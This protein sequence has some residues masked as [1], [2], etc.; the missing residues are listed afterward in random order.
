M[1]SNRSA[2]DINRDFFIFWAHLEVQLDSNTQRLLGAVDS[3]QADV[4]QESL[5][6]VLLPQVLPGVGDGGPEV[7]VDIL[8][9]DGGDVGVDERLGGNSIGLKWPQKW[10]LEKGKSP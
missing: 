6:H 2:R 8:P 7:G 4:F 9:H 1:L 5:A 3:G 10:I